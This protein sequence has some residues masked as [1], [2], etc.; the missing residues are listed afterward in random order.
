MKTIVAALV[1]VVL[2]RGCRTED[3]NVINKE[4]PHH[5]TKVASDLKKC[6]YGHRALRDIPIMYGLPMLEGERGKELEQ[7]LRNREITLGGCVVMPD[8]PK[9]QT[10]CLT[11]DYTYSQ[12]DDSWSRSDPD[13]KSFHPAISDLVK[14][15][16][17]PKTSES[18]YGQEVDHDG[19]YSETVSID[20]IL[21]FDE[22]K[23]YV[24]AWIPRVGLKQK[25]E[26]HLW[27]MLD[28]KDSWF[29]VGVGDQWFL[30][31]DKSYD[32]KSSRV[33]FSHKIQGLTRR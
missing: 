32:R 5:T 6:P 29:V 14:S 30:S 31:V 26:I 8:S 17:P 27:G 33:Y 4:Y 25:P 20:S 13:P 15:L 21:S 16:C 22:L 28:D 10:T 11:C 12:R 24:A 18:V 9:V 3:T 7:R 2:L 1:V 23:S 19:L